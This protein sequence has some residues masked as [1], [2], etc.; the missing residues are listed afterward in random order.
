MCVKFMAK[1]SYG[2]YNGMSYYSVVFKKDKK[3]LNTSKM[4]PINSVYVE[5]NHM[6]H[7]KS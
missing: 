2:A 6:L 7:L 3:Q 4:S 5:I 1:N